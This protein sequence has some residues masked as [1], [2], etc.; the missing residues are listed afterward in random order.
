[1][2]IGDITNSSYSTSKHLK[3]HRVESLRDKDSQKSPSSEKPE[4]NQ[5]VQD[6]INISE[7]ARIA[8]AAEQKKLQELELA[9][10]ALNNTPELSSSRKQEI[11]D[12]INSGYYSKPEV[13]DQ[14]A[15]KVSEDI[16]K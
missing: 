4:E 8:H 7:E 3:P 12:R 2:N 1:M 16:S 13:L 9:R 10:Q 15:S 14:I 11:L 6:S 5:E